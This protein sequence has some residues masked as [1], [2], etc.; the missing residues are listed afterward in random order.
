[1]TFP[2]TSLN[3]IVAR[4]QNVMGRIDR[5]RAPRAFRLWMIYST[6]CGDGWIWY[7]TAIF[8]LFAGGEQHYRALVSCTIAIFTGVALFTALK[9]VCRRPRP[10]FA[11]PRAFDVPEPPDQFSFP[12]GHTITAFAACVNLMHYY[13]EAS[14]VLLFCAAS[15]AAS[16]I[17]L[18]M[19]YPS[20][21]V[22][23]AAIGTG[24]GYSAFLLVGF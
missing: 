12:S 7:A 10:K 4:D 16:R 20:D 13:P 1:M 15:I 14:P 3:W 24:L 9:R 2:T 19:H 11:A 8:L 22:V 21:V 18:G 23:G 5:W 6:R 17:L